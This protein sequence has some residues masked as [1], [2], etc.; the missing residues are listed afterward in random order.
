MKSHTLFMAG[1]V[2][3]MFSLAACEGGAVPDGQ[4]PIIP[5]GKN[6]A[7]MS[8]EILQPSYSEFDL[9][10]YNGAISLQDK[11][12]CEKISDA[13]FKKIC[14]A[15]IEKKLII[16][17]A[18]QKMDPMICEKLNAKEDIETCKLQLE[19]N[20]KKADQMRRPNDAEIELFKKA[21]DNLD[22][23]FCEKIE[24]KDYKESCILYV[25]EVKTSQQTS[26]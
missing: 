21:Q 24:L 18:N 8:Q 6:Q 25:G 5:A 12:L 14:I 7:T 17:E 20:K 15:E 2:F 9:T 1:L 23:T 3:G 22:T 4:T 11:S 16:D 10:A 19:I 26:S 13:A